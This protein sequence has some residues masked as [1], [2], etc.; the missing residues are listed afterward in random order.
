VPGEYRA[1]LSSWNGLLSAVALTITIVLIILFA[2]S[3]A[4]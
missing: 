2:I 3:S 4:P 1:V